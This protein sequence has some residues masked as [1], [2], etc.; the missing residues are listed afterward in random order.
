MRV[1]YVT[2][3]PFEHL[4]DYDIQ[5]RTGD[6]PHEI[7]PIITPNDILRIAYTY[8]TV[9]F[10]LNENENFTAV[11]FYVDLHNQTC[12]YEDLILR[13]SYFLSIIC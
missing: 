1:I 3:P 10:I 7:H 13:L 11:L 2:F 6:R 8:N 12:L 5:D 4:F 9:F